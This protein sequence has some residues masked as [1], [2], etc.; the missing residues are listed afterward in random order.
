MT[1]R[2]FSSSVQGE[3]H[4]QSETECQDYHA[5]WLSPCGR[6]LVAIVC[7]GAGSANSASAGSRCCANAARE[8]IVA[9]LETQ[10]LADVTVDDVKML[11]KYARS[12]LS[13]LSE[14][15]GQEFKDFA[16][17]M[18]FAVVGDANAIFS[19]VGDGAIVTGDEDGFNVV[20][21][22]QSGEYANQT[23][24]VTDTDLYDRIEIRISS[25]PF[26]KLALFTDGIQELV[27][28]PRERTVFPAFFE[29]IFAQLNSATDD[30]H[31]LLEQEL[32]RF[33]MSDRV[34]SLTS[35]DKTLLLA[36]KYT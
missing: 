28:E 32:E 33:L 27:L 26:Q 11:W 1:W 18:A 3:S 25:H 29:S 36:F 19:Q 24:F 22:P 17:T 4:K 21:W 34:N 8:A 10:D 9:M 16:T 2:V 35:D 20:F 12:A 13:K 7:D 5:S 6:Y 30:Q 14:D 23:Y 15:S 31:E